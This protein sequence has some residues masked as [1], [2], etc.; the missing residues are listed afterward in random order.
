M[1]SKHN[2]YVNL[3]QLENLSEWDGEIDT[4]QAK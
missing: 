4:T 1:F 3:R 2:P